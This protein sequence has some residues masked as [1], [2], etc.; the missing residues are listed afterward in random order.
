MDYVSCISQQS[1]I[2]HFKKIRQKEIE[3]NFTRDFKDSGP[4]DY[5]IMLEELKD[6][7]GVLKMEK[8]QE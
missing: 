2:E 6:T 8:P 5:L 7:E 4:L 1:W 3:P